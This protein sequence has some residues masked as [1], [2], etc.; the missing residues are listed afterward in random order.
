M[1]FRKK[2]IQKIE[3]KGKIKTTVSLETEKVGRHIKSPRCQV[4]SSP[5]L[6][7]TGAMGIL[8]CFLVTADFDS[9]NLG[10]RLRFCISKETLVTENAADLENTLRVTRI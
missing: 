9:R 5:P 6:V 8:I 1:I 3:Y 2:K 4:T 10:Q 7:S